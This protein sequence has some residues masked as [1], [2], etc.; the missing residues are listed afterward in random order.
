M[1][2]F[3]AR[4]RRGVSGLLEADMEKIAAQPTVLVRAPIDASKVKWKRLDRTA[5]SVDPPNR[6]RDGGGRPGVLKMALRTNW[7][8]E[9][10]SSPGRRRGLDRLEV[11]RME[12]DLLGRNQRP[13]RNRSWCDR[14]LSMNCCCNKSSTVLWGKRA[15]YARESSN[16]RG[17]TGHPGGSRLGGALRRSLSGGS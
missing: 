5:P 1:G 17:P 14:L 9:P 11:A 15:G 8:P 4:G 16:F 7:K 3:A 6:R 12:N 2:G 13:G 10:S